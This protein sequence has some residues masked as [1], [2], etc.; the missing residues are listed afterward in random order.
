MSSKIVQICDRCG[1]EQDSTKASMLELAV[2]VRS[3]SMMG[4]SFEK[5][6]LDFCDRC[7]PIV[8]EAIFAKVKP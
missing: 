7:A 5:K 6:S 2:L 8:K 1:V 4:P 3:E